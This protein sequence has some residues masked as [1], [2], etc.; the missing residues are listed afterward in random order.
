MRGYPWVEWAQSSEKL[1]ML[2][3]NLDAIYMA[4][5]T[6][7]NTLRC[8]FMVYTIQYRGCFF[9]KWGNKT[10]RRAVHQDKWL[11]IFL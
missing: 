7:G 11:G 5:Y 1:V 9:K 3:C 4:I 10:K 2:F 8:T 6:L